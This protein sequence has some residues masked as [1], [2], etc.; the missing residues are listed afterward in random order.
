[1]R[2]LKNNELNAVSG[3]GFFGDFGSALGS[4][5][6]QTVDMGYTAINGHAPAISAV[7]ASSTLGNGIGLITD[8]I[9]NPANIPDA[10]SQIGAGI[11]GIIEA[12]KAN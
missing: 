5:I 6:G 7:T 11:S 8:S 9:F 1:M 2:D 10:I 3:G 12:A 4:A